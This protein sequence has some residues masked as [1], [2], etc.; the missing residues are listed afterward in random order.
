MVFN[1]CFLGTSPGRLLMLIW[2]GCSLLHGCYDA[3]K[4]LQSP[5]FLAVFHQKK[6][7]CLMFFR[8]RKM[9]GCQLMCITWQPLLHAFIG[10]VFCINTAL[11]CSRR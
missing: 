4:K 2:Q 9:P 5:N 1:I 11:L 3:A 10:A 8:I 6:T 7:V